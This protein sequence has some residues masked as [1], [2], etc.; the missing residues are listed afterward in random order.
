MDAFSID[1]GTIIYGIQS[2]KYPTIPC[3]GVIITARC[4]IAQRK[5]PKYY[6]LIAV[7]AS[8]WFCSE[9]GY[10][11]VYRATIKNLKNDIDCKAT[12]LDLNRTNT[13]GRT[14]TRSTR[15]TA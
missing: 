9:H 13:R 14:R 4:D 3:Y 10:E 2:A 5:V 11:L 1:Q 8:D 12:E 6:F 7:D 15:R